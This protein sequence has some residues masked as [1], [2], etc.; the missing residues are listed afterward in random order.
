MKFEESVSMLRKDKEDISE[1]LLPTQLAPEFSKQ[2]SDYLLQIRDR[3]DGASF[4]SKRK[5]INLLDVHGKL[6]IENA[7]RGIYLKCLILPRQRL[8]LPTSLL[9]NIG[10]T[11]TGVSGCR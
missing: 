7:E 1:Q 3:L 6:E 5:L 9:S 11:A 8:Q 4:E 2:L 10:E